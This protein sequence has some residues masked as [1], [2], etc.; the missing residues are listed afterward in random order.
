[1]L[2]AFIIEQI[3]KRDEERRRILERPAVQLP[4]HPEAPAEDAD[5]EPDPESEAP[6][7]IVIDI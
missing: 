7:V 5:V 4:L 3:R 2:D 6:R 1:M